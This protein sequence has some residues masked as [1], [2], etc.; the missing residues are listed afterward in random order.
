[1]TVPHF[2]AAPHLVATTD[3]VLTV[4]ERAARIFERLL[5]LE[6]LTPPLELPR[7]RVSMI[8]HQRQDADPAHRWL[9]EWLSATSRSGN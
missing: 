3:L 5:P 1:V 2:L 7:T 9:R 6:I 8:W 4:A